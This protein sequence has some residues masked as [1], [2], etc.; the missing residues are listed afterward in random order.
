MTVKELI[1]E[2]EKLDENK[3]ILICN[4][5]AGFAVNIRNIEPCE[6]HNFFDEED[7]GSYYLY[8][9]VG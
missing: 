8:P 3:Q 4:Y 2:L 6:E 9:N 5:E 7:I 1:K